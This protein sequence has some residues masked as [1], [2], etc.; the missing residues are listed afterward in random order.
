MQIPTPTSSSG[1]AFT[2]VSA[3]SLTPPNAPVN[4]AR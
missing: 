4:M 2:V 1:V 3:N